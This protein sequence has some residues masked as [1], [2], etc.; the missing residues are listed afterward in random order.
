MIEVG[1]LVRCVSADGML[2]LIVG[3]L[4][5]EH[6]QPKGWGYVDDI[7]HVRVCVTQQ[8]FPFLLKQLEKVQ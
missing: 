7:Y 4:E 1:D 8:E 3:Y 5:K 2:G 6:G